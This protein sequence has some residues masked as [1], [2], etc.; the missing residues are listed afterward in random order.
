MVDLAGGEVAKV[1]FRTPRSVAGAE[2]VLARWTAVTSST[3]RSRCGPPSPSKAFRTAASSRAWPAGSSSVRTSRRVAG[4]RTP[5]GPEPGQGSL[6]GL[7]RPDVPAECAGEHTLVLLMSTDFVT[8]AVEQQ[9]VP[10]T[11]G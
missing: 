10:I 3:N 4:T 5:D 9:R 11:I 8:D 6:T 7:V 2:R 1:T